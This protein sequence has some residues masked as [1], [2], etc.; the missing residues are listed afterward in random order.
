MQIQDSGNFLEF[1]KVILMQVPSNGEYGVSP[2]SS[3]VI[4]PYLLI[5]ASLPNCQIQPQTHTQLSD[6][7]C[8][9]LSTPQLISRLLPGLYLSTQHPT[10]P[11]C[12]PF[13]LLPSHIFPYSRFSLGY[14]FCT[15]VS[16]LCQPVFIPPKTFVT[17]RLSPSANLSSTPVCFVQS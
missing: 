3:L 8:L 17:S 1:M 11:S 12:T 14:M 6:I 13:H 2:G 10:G 7:L 5:H 4:F 9:F 16:L 15:P